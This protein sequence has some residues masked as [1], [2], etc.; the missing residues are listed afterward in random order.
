M[1]YKILKT[2]KLYDD[3]DR[4]IYAGCKCSYVQCPTEQAYLI[5]T[6]IGALSDDALTV[7]INKSKDVA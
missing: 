1:N 2:G 3:A 7:D 5:D 4:I 6:E